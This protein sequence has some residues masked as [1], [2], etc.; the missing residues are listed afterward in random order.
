MSPYSLLILFLIIF[1]SC[2]SSRIYEEFRDVGSQ[3]IAT[4]T[5]KFDVEVDSVNTRYTIDFH[6]KND[7]SYPF[8][9][10][11]FQILLI[12]EEGEEV[13]KDLK[14]IILFDPKTGKPQGSG[15][16]NSFE[17]TVTIYDNYTFDEPGTYTFLVNQF[18]RMDTL[19]SIERIGLRVGYSNT[20]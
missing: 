11:Y 16:A 5:L 6:V 17:N 13:L 2:D 19:P 15:L 1:S 10:L 12:N 14:E 7:I 4:D 8:N 3:W 18:M 9:N 20:P